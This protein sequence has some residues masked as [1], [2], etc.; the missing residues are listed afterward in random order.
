LLSVQRAEGGLL[1]GAD[2]TDGQAGGGQVTGLSDGHAGGE[3]DELIFE[4]KKN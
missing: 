2:G 3:N 4:R 1:A